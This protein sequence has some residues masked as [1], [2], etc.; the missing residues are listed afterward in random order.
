MAEPA[1]APRAPDSVSCREFNS[2]GFKVKKTRHG[3]L[4]QPTENQEM[5]G[6]LFKLIDPHFYPLISKSN[7]QFI[8]LMLEL[9]KTV[10]I[11]CLP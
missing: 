5:L 3:I 8:R 4:A 2:K 7:S 6:K 11:K 10:V 1:G 9:T